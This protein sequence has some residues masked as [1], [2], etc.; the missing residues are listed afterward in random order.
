[1]RLQTR[2]INTIND[3]V[4]K[5]FGNVNVYLFGSRVDD[6]KKGG[7]IDIAIDSNLSRVDFRRNKVKLISQLIKVDFDFKIDI[8]NYNT[9]D[10]LLKNQITENAQLLKVI[11]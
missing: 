3:A 11:T 1:M 5:S 8:V 7:D 6:S 10:Q 2:I 4:Q 9:K